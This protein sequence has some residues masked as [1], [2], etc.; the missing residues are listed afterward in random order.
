MVKH[1]TRSALGRFLALA[2]VTLASTSATASELRRTAIVRAVETC[3]PCIVNIQGRKT[4]RSEQGS[5]NDPFRQ[6]NGMGTGVI[7]D[8]R[9]YIVTNYHV[10]EGVTRIQVTTDQGQTMIGRLVAH[11]RQTDLALLHVSSSQKLPVIPMG[12]S[13]DLLLA[14]PVVAIGNAYGY[15]HTVTRGIISQLH[16][17]VQVS[18]TQKYRNLIQTDASINPGNSGGP[19]I[20][21]DGKIIG[22]N[23]AVRVGAQ[24]IGF[25]IPV[26]DAMEIAA[27]L[28]QA[29]QSTSLYHGLQL[30]TNYADEIP[31]LMVKSVSR[32]SPADKTGIQT[33]DHITSV[34]GVV[35]NRQLDFERVLLTEEVGDDIQLGVDRSGTTRTLKLALT[36]RPGNGT[37]TPVADMPWKMLG[38]KLSKAPN[39]EFTASRYRGGLR[40]VDVRAGSPASDQGIVAGDTLVG[41]EDYE[42][43]SL[44]NVAY[45]LKNTDSTQLQ[46]LKFFIVREKRTLYGYLRL[47]SRR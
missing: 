38:L 1:L 5:S 10:V 46:S 9:G 44:E 14:E 41:M 42:T 45:I 13:H 27:R 3:R 47:A 4:V 23:V 25:A 16:R 21:I 28:I 17:T 2:L 19:L 32:G 26:D 11:D 20:N 6:V 34:N 31:Q 30:Q 8:E 43:I 12:R 7:I 36:T 24:G 37:K 18:D 29:E 15:E 39:S 35:V 22:I 40:V 33:G